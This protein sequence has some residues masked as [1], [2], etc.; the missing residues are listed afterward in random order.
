M[1]DKIQSMNK[2]HQI[3]VG[4]IIGDSAT[5]LVRVGLA[6]FAMAQDGQHTTISSLLEAGADVNSTSADGMSPLVL[7]T[8]RGWPAGAQVLLEH[9]A[10][11]N[12][13]GTGYTAS[14]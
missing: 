10:N 14:T 11:P 7:A 3:L 2:R 4:V 1:S 5:F 12:A 6:P 13:A 8:V 9:G